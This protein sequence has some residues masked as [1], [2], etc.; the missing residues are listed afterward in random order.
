MQKKLTVV[1]AALGY[2]LL[3]GGCQKTTDTENSR[4]ALIENANNERYML[5]YSKRARDRR[6]QT[7]D[8]KQIFEKQKQELL[9]R[10]GSYENYQKAVEAA[11]QRMEEKY[12]QR[13]ARL[14]SE[15]SNAANSSDRPLICWHTDYESGV[16]DRLWVNK[17]AYILDYFE[18]QGFEYG[19]DCDRAGT[20]TNCVAKITKGY[21]DDSDQSGLSD[22]EKNLGYIL[23]CAT[24]ADSDI[25]MLGGAFEKFLWDRF[26]YCSPY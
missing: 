12:R 20:G 8:L 25:E 23:P 14:D 19:H 3:I 13:K 18:M 1:I 17:W 15:G 21:Y 24:Y 10:Y 22:C 9:K 6:R 5:E 7:I 4:E 16:K 26:H 11:Y 2:V